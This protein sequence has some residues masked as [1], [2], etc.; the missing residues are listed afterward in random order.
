ML[1]LLKLAVFSAGQPIQEIHFEGEIGPSFVE[2]SNAQVRKLVQQFLKVQD[3]P[4]PRGVAPGERPG[5]KPKRKQ[6]RSA[7]SLNLY[8]A[9]RRVG[10]RARAGRVS[11]P[12]EICGPP[13]VITAF[14]TLLA[15][16]WATWWR[17]S[18]RE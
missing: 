12:T 14:P 18:R 5:R 6:K 3:S 8:D 1:R 16:V 17:C 7:E 13:P 10:I 9:S 4:G 2:A 15:L 11:T